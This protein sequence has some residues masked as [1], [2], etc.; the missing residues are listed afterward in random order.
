[1]KV[2]DIG[3]DELSST[4]LRLSKFY[5]VCILD[6]CGVGHQGSHLMIAGIE[7]TDTLEF[8]SDDAGES[9]A[10]LE[11][12]LSK[13]KAAF[14]TI[15][16]DLGTTFERLRSKRSLAKEQN[17]DIFVSLFDTLSVHDYNDG[18]TRVCGMKVEAV[19][20]ALLR[21]SKLPFGA[22]AGN[23]AIRT[24]SN[25][26]RE[27]Y[28]A[29]IETIKEFIRCGDT[30]QANLTQQI[31][32]SL[33]AGA[34]P[35]MIFARLRREHPAPFA[36]FLK[37]KDSTVVSASP[38]RFFRIN[39]RTITTSP[40]KG[41]SR[42][43]S[44]AKEDARLRHQLANSEKDRAENTMIVDLLRNDLGRVCE[45]GS[46]VVE[47][48]C[49]IEEHPTL[50]HLVSTIKGRMREGI[51]FIDVIRALFPCG[52][53][54]GAPKIRTM[55]ILD[56]IETTPRGL[57][58]GAI[59]YFI[60]ETGFEGLTPGFDLSVAI[61]T[62]VIRGQEAVFNVGGGI[63]IDSDPEAEYDES[64]LKAKA[65]LAALGNKT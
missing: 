1:M 41:T 18:S 36:A 26:T 15:A 60:P 30:Y 42:R 22:S 54:T 3:G 50:F 38:E 51:G 44:D 23:D 39:D 59:G 52:S 29:A 56:E 21:E 12:H 13:G 37:R 46:V 43:G 24:T 4:L 33:P 25:F 28:V 57:S 49:E 40:I 10:M 45:Y 7:P 2:I 65:L 55:E 58:M 61:R 64:M 16:Y 35:E 48:L 6:S 11:R 19:A 17:A 5:R 27:Q 20:E 47:R 9:L 32:S 63:T 53:I 62:M 34:T 31:T 8:T 14:F